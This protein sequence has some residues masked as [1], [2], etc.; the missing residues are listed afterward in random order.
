MKR[1][2]VGIGSNVGKRLWHLYWG[3]GRLLDLDEGAVAS[4]IYETPPWGGGRWGPYW[5]AVVRLRTELDAQELV[6]WF[7]T[8]EHEYG[9]LERGWDVP[10]R[11]DLDL[12]AMEDVRI[13]R[14][15]LQVPHR[16][17]HRRW[18]VLRPFCDLDPDWRHPVWGLTAEELLR[19]V[20]EREPWQKGKRVGE[21]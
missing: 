19:W 14:P 17:M 11:L 8:W 7:L 9:R 12:L 2:W 4:P 13:W 21:L 6:S 20:E 18:F 5:N 1:V 3:Y 16:Y 10:R 15:T